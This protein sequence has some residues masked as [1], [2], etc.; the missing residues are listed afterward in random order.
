MAPHPPMPPIMLNIVVFG[1]SGV[2]KT[3]FADMFT[4]GNHFVRYDPFQEERYRRDFN[5]NGRP[6]SL[7]L[8]DLSSTPQREENSY[9]SAAMHYRK[10]LQEADGIVLLYDIT[11]EESFEYITNQAYTY[12]Y[13][14]RKFLNETLGEGGL[15]GESGNHQREEM[16]KEFGCVLV[17]NKKDLMGSGKGKRAIAGSMAKEWA[18]SQGFEHFEVSSNDR[19]EVE[20]AMRT[21]VKRTLVA[22]KQNDQ[23]AYLAAEPQRRG[24]AEAERKAHAKRW[25]Q[26]DAHQ[27][28]T[29]FK[30]KVKQVFRKPKPIATTTH[31]CALCQQPALEL[32][33]VPLQLSAVELP[34]PT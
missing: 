19:S 26:Y 25:A 6:V 3:C 21:L 24:Q 29:T 32:R 27:P 4:F 7:S 8:D 33:R 13:L 20:E 11:N 14:C 5:V 22:K 17:G 9:I 16:T 1:E 2:G 12:I 34:H 10:I 30:S 23:V 28:T 18:H 15:R 31:T